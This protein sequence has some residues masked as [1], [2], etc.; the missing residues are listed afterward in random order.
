MDSLDQVINTLAEGLKPLVEHIESKPLTTQNH[1]GDYMTALSVVA[2]KFNAPSDKAPEMQKK[3]FLAVGIAFQR[4]GANK[5]GV[6]AAL[7]ALGHF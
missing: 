3:I 2:E 6:K 5:D 7:K 1:Y 4:A